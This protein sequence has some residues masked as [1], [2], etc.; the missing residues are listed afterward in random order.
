[1]GDEDDEDG[2]F[3]KHLIIAFGGIIMKDFDDVA[4]MIVKIGLI[5]KMAV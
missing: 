3:T 2:D 5:R 1:M 4:E